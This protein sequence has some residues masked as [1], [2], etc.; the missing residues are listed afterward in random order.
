AKQTVDLAR[1]LE[2]DMLSRMHDSGLRDRH[3]NLA[4]LE[5]RWAL[6]RHDWVSA[7]TLPLRRS[8]YPYAEAIPHYARAVGLARSGH[9]AQAQHEID[10]L[11][12]IAKALTDAKNLYWAAQVEIERKIAASWTAHALGHDGEALELMQAASREED[13]LETHDTLNPGPI[14]MT[15]DEGLGVLLLELN[16]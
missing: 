5:A 7:S 15:A 4:A 14:G 1:Q 3:Y 10:Q 8:R 13:G 12:A 6:E 16:R 9:P 11:V 2:D